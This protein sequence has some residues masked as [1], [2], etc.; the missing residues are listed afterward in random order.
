[1]S[2][3]QYTFNKSK[4]IQG[5]CLEKML[6]IPDKSIDMVLCDLPYQKTKNKWDTMIPFEPLWEQYSRVIK[7]NGVIILFGQKEF[8]A[9][10]IVS[11]IKMYKYSLVWD[12]VNPTGFLNAKRMPMTVHEDILVFYKKPP[13]YNP[14]KYDSGTPSHASNN[15]EKSTK[16]SN[17]GEHMYVDNS[18]EY[19][20]MKYPRT[21]LSFKKDAPTKLLHPTQ[22]PIDLLEYLIITFSN[23]GDM[24]LDNT[25]GSGSTGEACINTDRD[26]IDRKSVV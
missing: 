20:N 25:A 6:S 2:D 15:G 12:K 26:F 24:V 17:Y 8:S 19:G 21:I 16:N 3:T 1:M 14:Q 22:K 13:T 9:R 18:K 23:S 7:D 4:I 10:L 11:N 5:D